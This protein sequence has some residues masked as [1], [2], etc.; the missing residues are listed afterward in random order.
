MLFVSL[1][2]Y[3]FPPKVKVGEIYAIDENNKLN[4]HFVK[5]L[6][7]KNNLIVYRFIKK[8]HRFMYGSNQLKHIRDFHFIYKKTKENNTWIMRA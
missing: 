8:N 6:D 7:V 4:E 2:K 5:I 1:L 3:I